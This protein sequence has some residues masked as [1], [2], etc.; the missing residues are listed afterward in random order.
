MADLRHLPQIA[1]ARTG[2]AGSRTQ[3]HQAMRLWL[4]MFTCSTLIENE[5][6]SRMRTEFGSTLPRFDMM[7]HLFQEPDGIKMTELSRRMMVTNGNITGITD[8]L[9]KQGLVERVKVLNDRRSSII[10]LTD[11]GHTT[12]V[13]MAQ[14]HEQWLTSLFEGLHETS[15][16]SLFESLGELKFLTSSQ[17]SGKVGPP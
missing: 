17:L 16:K 4:R 1:G 12:F 14:A 7:S 8:H 13:K 11:K 2:K 10:R 5:L 15:R 9:E 6:R 3:N